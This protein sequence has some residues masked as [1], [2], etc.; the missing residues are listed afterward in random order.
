MHTAW[1]THGTVN[2]TILHTTA[3]KFI[4]SRR[5]YLLVSL[6]NCF[7][8]FYARQQ[9]LLSAFLSHRYSVRLS[10][11]PSVTRVDQSKTAQDRITKSSPLVPGRL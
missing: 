5:T 11:R 4:F 2:V 7:D 1:N 9:L 10:V 6:A 8:F 3:Q